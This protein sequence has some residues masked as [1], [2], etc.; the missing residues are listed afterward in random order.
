[1]QVIVTVSV[2][3]LAFIVIGRSCLEGCLFDSHCRPGSFL[4]FNYRPVMYRASSLMASS[5]ILGPSI[6]VKFPLEPLNL[7]VQ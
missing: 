5:V 3:A 1:M 2:E 7:I 6:W 4:R